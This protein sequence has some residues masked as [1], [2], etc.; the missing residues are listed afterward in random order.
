MKDIKEFFSKARKVA[1][2]LDSGEYEV[3]SLEEAEAF[4]N[5]RNSKGNI[6]SSNYYEISCAIDTI[7]YKLENAA[8]VLEIIAESL[9]DDPNSGAVWCIRDVI[10]RLADEA[11][12][13][14]GLSMDC[15]AEEQAILEAKTVA[16]TLA[17]PKK[18]K[19]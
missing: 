10:E 8:D 6:M 11:L 2:D 9:H 1:T 18:K 4:A 15:H 7:Q 13:V 16:K 5:K 19:K 14:S 12:N 17:K 3:C